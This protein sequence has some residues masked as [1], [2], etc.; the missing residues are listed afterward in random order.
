MSQ[1]TRPPPD[2]VR[3]GERIPCHGRLRVW[4][5]SGESLAPL[6]RCLD[7]GLG[8]LRGVASHGIAPGT[9]VAL[10]VRLPTGR[11]F[12]S[13]GRVAWSKTTLHPALL[14]SPRGNG[15]DAIFGIAFER[16]STEDLLPIARLLVARRD[17]RRR[18]RRIRRLHGLPIR[19]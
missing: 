6:G 8:G 10:E 4:T 7:I 19:P 3:S 11:T 15:E 9:V 17:E 1:A 16:V 14:G 2:V 12:R 13:D 18:A 5:A